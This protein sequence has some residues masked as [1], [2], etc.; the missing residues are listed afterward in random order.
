MKN[1]SIL[2][3]HD[4]NGPPVSEP[5]VAEN[6]DHSEDEKQV[7]KLDLVTE[8]SRNIERDQFRRRLT[9]K[10]SRRIERLPELSSEKEEGMESRLKKARVNVSELLHD[11]F[12]AKAARSKE[13]QRHSRIGLGKLLFLGAVSKQWHA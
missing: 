7:E 1:R 4:D 6:E 9:S 11:A 2:P 12:L 5:P 8:E 13:K 10:Q 3:E